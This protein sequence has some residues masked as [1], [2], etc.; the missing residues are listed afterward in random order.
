MDNGMLFVKRRSNQGSGSLSKILLL[1]IVLPGKQE[2]ERFNFFSMLYA[3]QLSLTAKARYEKEDLSCLELEGEEEQLKRFVH[4]CKSR[5]NCQISGSMPI[6][7]D[8]VA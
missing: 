5:P 7:T 8:H 3:S 2:K 4:W 1:N 6:L